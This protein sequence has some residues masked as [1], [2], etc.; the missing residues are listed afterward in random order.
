[1]FWANLTDSQKELVQQYVKKGKLEIVNCGISMN[2]VLLPNTQE[3]LYN[4]H[5][6]RNWCK[7]HLG[8]V[9]K[10]S[11]FL[12]P[13][14]FSRAHARILEQMGFK[15]L[16]INR[17][18]YKE[19]EQR[20]RDSK[21]VFN[22]KTM[23]HT[24]GLRTALLPYHYNGSNFS[25]VYSKWIHD[26]PTLKTFNLFSR[27]TRLIEDFLN[28]KQIY[29]S[30][31]FFDLYG[32]D[33]T[34]HD[35]EITVGGYEKLMAFS[36]YNPQRNGGINFK[37]ATI[38]EFFNDLDEVNKMNRRSAIV[39]K[40]NPN[41]VPYIDKFNSYWTGFYSTRPELKSAI[42]RMIATYRAV[43]VLSAL[44]LL[45]VEGNSS[46]ER[47]RD[48]AADIKVFNEYLQTNIGVLLHHDAIT[49]TSN[50]ATIVDYLKM[51]KKSNTE[52]VL[53]LKSITLIDRFLSRKLGLLQA[54]ISDFF[55]C[56]TQDIRI[57][58]LSPINPRATVLA[59]LFNPGEDRLHIESV[60]LPDANVE[61]LDSKDKKIDNQ[62]VC[63]PLIKPGSSVSQSKSC[64][65]YF[66][67]PMV[68]GELKV[69]KFQK[70]SYRD[71]LLASP[72]IETAGCRQ[73]RLGEKSII[74]LNCSGIPEELTVVN[75]DGEEFKLTVALKE[76]FTRDSGPYVFKPA[77]GTRQSP[78]PV[79]GEYLKG[80]AVVQTAILFE[81]RFYYSEA[82][83][84]VKYYKANAK[85]DARS[86]NFT[87]ELV[88]KNKN[89]RLEDTRVYTGREWVIEFKTSWV[90][91]KN[92]FYS[93]NGL[94]LDIVD[95]P[96][97][98][99]FVND[100]ADDFHLGSCKPI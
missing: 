24:N 52:A 29:N 23:N 78:K 56:N 80:V 97:F 81:V 17:I 14:G 10:T 87:V 75:E 51:V 88:K 57:C 3:I 19:K 26:D 68:R 11:W 61:L 69:L 5:N 44:S 84:M 59:L 92:F 76:Y 40:E 89:I 53:H 20:R 31:V 16:V 13:F 63:Y 34:H 64:R 96:R 25:V 4:F 38:S 46:L 48:E 33:F 85:P 79:D 22:W 93:Q 21:L 95:L 18:N 67:L 9:S 32:D 83:V 42:T 71:S 6:G 91:N 100:Y 70:V 50:I 55:I 62:I 1:M 54:D 82:S 43:S 47:S 12:D 49:C 74:K 72:A 60:I 66:Q 90:R 65:M 45:Q 58:M 99:R 77:F 94:D 2:D 98:S 86:M 27:F 37:F 30:N 8:K 39:P 15:N 73:Y 36:Q 41:F 28:L 35:F 7:E